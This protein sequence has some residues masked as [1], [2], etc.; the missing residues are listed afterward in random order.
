[1]ACTLCVKI[2]N[3]LFRRLTPTSCLKHRDNQMRFAETRV[4][5]VK[6]ASAFPAPCTEP[7]IGIVSCTPS[8]RVFIHPAWGDRRGYIKL[9]LAIFELYDL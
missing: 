6:R 7:A 4:P 9:G 2:Q 3:R 5:I 1:M 8:A